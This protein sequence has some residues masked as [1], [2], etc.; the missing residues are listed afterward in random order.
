MTGYRRRHLGPRIQARA[1]FQYRVGCVFQ[2]RVW[3]FGADGPWAHAL[4][5]FGFRAIAEGE[6]AEVG[7]VGEPADLQFRCAGIQRY[8]DPVP[9]V[10][11][12]DAVAP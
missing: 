4:V 6:R 3:P 10:A 12:L 5:C 1:P 2:F 11:V 7:T 9:D 8:R